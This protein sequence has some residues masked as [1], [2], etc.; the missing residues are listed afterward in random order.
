MLKSVGTQ[1]I[2]TERL[3]LRQFC[4]EDVPQMFDNWCNDKDVTR[5]LS[6]NEHGDINVTKSICASWVNNYSNDGLN[7]NWAIVLKETNQ[8]IGSISLL[9]VDNEKNEAEVGYAMGKNFWDNGYMT[10]AC[11]AVIKYSFENANFDRLYARHHIDNHAS[12]KVMLK[13]GLRYID[14]TLGPCLKDKTIYVNYK[15]YEIIKA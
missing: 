10:E 13:S 2:E 1:Q 6:W 15:N 7:F 4:L 14:T 12:G 8:A 5:F 3:I 9:N 11:K